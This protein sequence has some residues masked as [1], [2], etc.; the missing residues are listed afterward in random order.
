LLELFLVEQLTTGDAVDLRAQ[1]GDAILVGE[2]HF[3]LTPD[4]TREHAIAEGK[5]RS[6]AKRPHRHHHQ[7]ANHNPKRHRPDADLASAM[8]QCVVAKATGMGAVQM[9][10][11][12]AGGL[13]ARWCGTARVIGGWVIRM[14]GMG[15]RR[16][17]PVRARPKPGPARRYQSFMVK[18]AEIR[19]RPLA[20]GAR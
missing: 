11:Y 12:G 7:R 4:Q 3:S 2:L 18:K 8:H 15:H 19:A 9:A 6:G 10:G 13:D 20:G 16:S 1:F 5:V 17:A 14:R